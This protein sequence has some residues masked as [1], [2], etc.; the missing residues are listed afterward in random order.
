MIIAD[1]PQMLTVKPSIPVTFIIPT[2]NAAGIL[3]RCLSAIRNQTYPQNL[4]EILVADGGSA[5]T[6]KRI[7]GSYGARVIPNPRVTHESGKSLALSHARGK[8]VFFTDAD[9]VIVGSDWV[10]KMVKA[11]RETGAKG[12]LPRTSAPPDSSAINRYL[13]HLFTDPFTWFVYSGLAHPDG[14]SRVV[15]PV[16][17]TTDYYL[18]RFGPGRTPLFGL[19]QGSGIARPFS[20]DG[21]A[22]HDDILAGVKLISEGG[23]ICYVPGA[24]V[25]HYHVTG[26]TSYIRKYSDRIIRNLERREAGMGFPDRWK[27][28]DSGKKIRSVL[29]ILYA[30]SMVWPLVDA[31]RLVRKTRDPVM[32]WHVPAS[33]T[34][35]L[36]IIGYTARSGIS[37]LSRTIWQ[38]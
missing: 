9:N 10:S 7:A 25:Y 34:L 26:F 21:I 1:L 3:T 29:F 33:L 32:V 15:K 22:W 28:L 38:A 30:L 5:D 2:L 37:R 8:L 18:Y 27:Y 12:Y 13:G 16:K 11:Y 31:V 17:R 36:L 20:R 19:S 14:F 6:T 35:A 23:L 24:R 4:I